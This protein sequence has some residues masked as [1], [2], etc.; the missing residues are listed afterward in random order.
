MPLKRHR[1]P[2]HCSMRVSKILTVGKKCSAGKP[3]EAQA[4]ARARASTRP[5]G[6][7][8]MM[9]ML[10]E[11]CTDLWISQ[12]SVCRSELNVPGLARLYNLTASPSSASAPSR[13][14]RS[15]I[16]RLMPARVENARADCGSKST[17]SLASISAPCRARFLRFRKIKFNSG[18]LS[19]I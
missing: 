9:T 4:L 11:S 18:L 5:T 14:S 15:P 13:P 16:L 2:S 17:A 6:P 12:R 3:F 1:P 8:P 19:T 7:A 10:A